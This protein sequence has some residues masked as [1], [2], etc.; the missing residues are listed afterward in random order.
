MTLAV[1]GTVRTKFAERTH[2]MTLSTRR[3]RRTKIAFP[4]NVVAHVSTD[5]RVL[6]V[7]S[8]VS[9]FA[10]VLASFSHISRWTFALSR[11]GLAATAVEAITRLFTVF[12]VISG[13]ATQ[14]TKMPE[15]TGFTVTM[16]GEPIAH[17]TVMALAGE[18]AVGPEFAEGTDLVASIA[19]PAHTAVTGTRGR[20]TISAVFTR[21]SLFTIFSIQ[22]LLADLAASW[23]IITRGT[24][25]FSRF[26][27][28]G[29]VIVTLAQLPAFLTPSAGRTR[30]L[31]S[32]S[33]PSRGTLTFAIDRIAHRLVPA[34]TFQNT[35]RTKRAWQALFVTVVASEPRFTT[36]FTRDRITKG[37]GSRTIARKS[38]TITIRSFG[39]DFRTGEGGEAGWALTLAGNVIAGGRMGTIANLIAFVAP[40]AGN[41]G[42][43][44]KSTSPTWFANAFSRQRVTNGSILTMTLFGAIFSIIP[45]RARHFASVTRPPGSAM[46]LAIFRIAGQGIGTITT[47][48][49]SFSEE[50][51]RAV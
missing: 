46:T 26:H 44:A 48:I 1:V 30:L 28:T 10:R 2:L 36:A 24:T 41:A 23:S 45:S 39:T 14:L 18:G 42:P 50:S 38:A 12:S 8:I 43:F 31:A 6:T 51:F 33:D 9:R 3:A 11:R 47:L 34:V 32:G 15:I 17:A 7:L 13:G 5:A 16:T 4:G 19:G 25:A 49:T 27:V 35:I 40:K 20:M 37:I 29:G 22:V 21:A